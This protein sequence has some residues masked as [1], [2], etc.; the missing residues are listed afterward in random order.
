MNSVSFQGKFYFNPNQLN[1]L[2]MWQK[3]QF[4]QHK[5]RIID[6]YCKKGT[7]PVFSQGKVI[8]DIIDSKENI[9]KKLSNKFGLYIEKIK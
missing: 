5:D 6:T 2:T 4:L 3:F 1:H 8:L 7:E 9:F